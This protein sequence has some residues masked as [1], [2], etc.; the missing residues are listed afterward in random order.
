MH[1][2]KENNVLPSQTI[3]SDENEEALAGTAT[4]LSLISHPTDNSTSQNLSQS[5]KLWNVTDTSH[6]TALLTTFMTPFQIMQ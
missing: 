3:T 4:T 6:I 1:G 2:A 5:S